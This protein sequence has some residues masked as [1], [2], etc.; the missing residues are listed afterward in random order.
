MSARRRRMIRGGR[1]MQPPHVEFDEAFVA[2]LRA[3]DE[4]AFRELVMAL[5]G[6]LRRLARAY[7][8]DASVVEEAVQETWLGV[9]RG[10]AGFEGRS[11][12]RS[13]IFAI[14]VHQAKKRAVRA[15]TRGLRES[16]LDMFTDTD[17]LAGGF[18]EDGHWRAP[19]DPWDLRN[20]EAEFLTAEAQQVIVA[21]LE[22]MPESQRAGWCSSGTSRA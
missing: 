16:Q 14:L 21:A 19:P 13:W 9:V 1:E 15:H 18:L 10:I 20:P 12:L 2:R 5:H 6:S 3:G 11:P 8:R 4:R 7:S 17:P 22:A